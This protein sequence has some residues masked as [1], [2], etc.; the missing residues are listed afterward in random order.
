MQNEYE[1]VAEQSFKNYD[2]NL[3]DEKYQQIDKILL[4]DKELN[5]EYFNVMGSMALW[6]FHLKNYQ[7]ENTLLN[8]SYCNAL[9][10][11]IQKNWEKWHPV[12]QE[13]CH[14]FLK[15]NDCNLDEVFKI[16]VPDLQQAKAQE[17]EI[18]QDGWIEYLY[19]LPLDEGKQLGEYYV[20]NKD[21]RKEIQKMYATV[22]EMMTFSVLQDN[23]PVAKK[24][25]HV[26]YERFLH[27][28][29]MG[30][31][32]TRGMAVFYLKHPLIEEGLI[33]HTSMSADVV[34]HN[35]DNL[36]ERIVKDL[37]NVLNLKPEL[38]IL[39]II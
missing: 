1:K 30:D 7:K 5:D 27:E 14:D 2:A 15:A 4:N 39:K 25:F 36:K 10:E 16:K 24:E 35:L 33:G 8:E 34:R 12:I 32:A 18:A 37:G 28:W 21:F 31:K 20:A 13:M 23:L 6:V 3:P 19:S 11:K 17:E 22:T 26:L 38:K 9:A 29:N